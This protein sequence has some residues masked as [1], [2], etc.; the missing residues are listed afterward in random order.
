MLDRVIVDIQGRGSVAWRRQE[1]GEDNFVVRIKHPLEND[2]QTPDLWPK[3][4]ASRA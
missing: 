2:P 1:Q 4:S 3:L